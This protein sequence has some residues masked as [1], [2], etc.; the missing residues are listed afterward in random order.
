MMTSLGASGAAAHSEPSVN[1]G[2]QAPHRNDAGH[3]SVPLIMMNRVG[4]GIARQY[5]S[6]SHRLRKGQKE[7]HWLSYRNE[8]ARGL[9]Q[10]TN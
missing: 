6:N 5:S 3:N 9:S 8:R 7:R 1:Q 4:D 10:G 2:N